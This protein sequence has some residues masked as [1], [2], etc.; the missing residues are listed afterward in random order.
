MNIGAMT[1]GT[2]V[3]FFESMVK[4]SPMTPNNG[5]HLQCLCVLLNAN[6][7]FTYQISGAYGGDLSGGAFSPIEFIKKPQVIVRFVTLVSVYFFYFIF[8]LSL[9]LRFRS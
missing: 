4:S 5:K 7:F 9:S 1:I 8:S 3:E 2:I 6:Y